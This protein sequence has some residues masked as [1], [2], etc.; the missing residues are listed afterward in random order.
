MEDRRTQRRRTRRRGRSKR[1]RGRMTRGC[2]AGGG[3]VY[4]RIRIH[5]LV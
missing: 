1:V 2:G 4:F 3:W 5:T